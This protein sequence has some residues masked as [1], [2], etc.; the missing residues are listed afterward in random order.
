MGTDARTAALQAIGMG[1][2][3]SACWRRGAGKAKAALVTAITDVMCNSKRIYTHARFRGGSA[4]SFERAEIEMSERVEFTA[5]WQRFGL[6]ELEYRAM[7]ADEYE[8]FKTWWPPSCIVCAVSLLQPSKTGAPVWIGH[9]AHVIAQCYG[10][11]ECGPLIN[12]G[13]TCAL[14][15]GMSEHGMGTQIA[16][17]FIYSFCAVDGPYRTLRFARL[18][19][20]LARDRPAVLHGW[21]DVDYIECHNLMTNLFC[22]FARAWEP[23]AL[24]KVSALFRAELLEVGVALQMKAAVQASLA[25]AQL[26]PAPVPE[27]PA[28]LS[29]AVSKDEPVVDM[30]STSLDSLSRLCQDKFGLET[31]EFKKKDLGLVAVYNEAVWITIGLTGFDA[32]FALKP[33]DA[34]TYADPERATL[35]PALDVDDRKHIFACLKAQLPAQAFTKRQNELTQSL[36]LQAVSSRMALQT[37]Q[38][39]KTTPTEKRVIDMLLRNQTWTELER[40]QFEKLCTAYRGVLVDQCWLTNRRVSYDNVYFLTVYGE[41]LRHDH[42][43]AVAVLWARLQRTDQALLRY[44]TPLLDLV[45]SEGELKSIVVEEVFADCEECV[46]LGASFKFVLAVQGC[47]QE[48]CSMTRARMVIVEPVVRRRSI[49]Y[50]DSWMVC[51]D[52]YRRLGVSRPRWKDVP[53]S[54]ITGKEPF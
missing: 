41:V 54:A 44:Y 48:D 25:A 7:R 43:D 30:V 13:P 1:R 28:P 52:C 36:S 20:Q 8:K 39:T 45:K 29:P 47:T 33:C 37:L 16:F 22:S 34:P 11:P 46:P 19:Y 53:M 18:L 35:L 49:G 42:G 27:L 10:A 4:Q 24:A 23:A 9:R 12:L 17:Q 40:S 38:D 51:V 6:G 32:E 15:N 21:S 2:M 5:H 3:A 26:L 50:I 14:H 31:L